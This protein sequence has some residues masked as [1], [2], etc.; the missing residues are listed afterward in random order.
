[1][2]QPARSRKNRKKNRG[3]IGR[4][5]E[6]GGDEEIRGRKMFRNK[7]NDRDLGPPSIYRGGLPL[8]E[9]RSNAIYRVE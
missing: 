2:E 3:S 6:D 4:R 7:R 9:T 5:R 8:R 1:M